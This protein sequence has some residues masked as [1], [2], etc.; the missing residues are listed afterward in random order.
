MR[1]KAVERTTL[2]LVAFIILSLC[3]G[4]LYGAEPIATGMD[5][6]QVTLQPPESDEARQYLGLKGFD[7]F[8]LSDIPA[9]LIIMEVFYVL[10]L[11]CQKAAPDINKL[12]GFIEKDPDLNANMK[13]FGLGIRG[14]HKKLGVYSKQFR[15]KFP[16]LPDPENEVFEKLG[17]P[18]I[19]FLMVISSSGK[20]LLTHSGPIKST[21]E[22]FSEIKKLYQEQ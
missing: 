14:D 9:K 17:E 18:K 22:L 16:L 20:V 2:W 8:A 12:F 19:P 13:M 3:C 10:C 4:P 11:D 5:F 15:V 7:P 1:K 6:P 21:E